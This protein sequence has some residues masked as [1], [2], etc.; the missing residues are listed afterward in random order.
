MAISLSSITKNKPKPARIAIHGHGG[1]GKSTFAAGAKNPIFI[2]AEDG[3]GKIDVPCF[4]LATCYQDIMD[5]M[6]VLYT[7]KHKY[8][9]VVIDSVDWIE[10]LVWKE[11]CDGWTDKDGNLKG[12]KSIEDAGYGKGYVE[13]QIYWKQILDGL[14]ALRNKGMQIILILHSAMV[15]VE[16]P[17][18]ESYDRVSFKLHKRAAAIIA[19]YC[20]VIL[21]ADMHITVTKEKEGFNKTK[22]RALTNDKRIVYTSPS[23]SILAKN[24]YSLPKTMDLDWKKFEKEI[25]K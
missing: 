5:A 14:N 2:L 21:Y 23:P 15:K 10:P 6:G 17:M 11:T 18:R 3:L 12:L 25:S 7:E 16:D 8:E 1:I 22:N 4:P 24:R 20:D 9:T 13:A 19:E